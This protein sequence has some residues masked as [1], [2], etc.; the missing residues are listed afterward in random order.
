MLEDKNYKEVTMELVK[1]AEVKLADLFKGAPKL[2]DSTKESLVKIWPW[3]AL[4]GGVLQVWAALSAFFWAQ[5]AND[6][7]NSVNE[8][9]RSIGAPQAVDERFTL[10]LWLAIAFLAV[11][12][13]LLLVAFPKL[14]NRLKS[15]WDLLFI[16]GLLNVVYAVVSLFSEY[17]GGLF[18]L[19]WNLF[20]TAVIFWLLFA[21]RDKYKGA[22]AHTAT[23]VENKTTEEK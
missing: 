20:V 11:E 4:I 8:F 10:W 17:R 23:K 6:L 1:K 2:S 14:R 3:L 19:I 7:T 21:V 16:V 22:A 13:V 18:G 15:G 5:K 9:Y 12:G